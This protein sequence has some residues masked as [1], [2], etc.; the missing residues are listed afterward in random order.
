MLRLNV[1]QKR[2]LEVI[3]NASRLKIPFA[4]WKYNKELRIYKICHS[5]V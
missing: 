5:Q 4:L 3:G 1:A 2:L